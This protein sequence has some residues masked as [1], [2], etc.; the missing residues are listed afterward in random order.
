VIFQGGNP[1]VGSVNFNFKNIENYCK[2]HHFNLL[3][4]DFFLMLDTFLLKLVVITVENANLFLLELLV[5]VI[6]NII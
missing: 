2:E 5:I 3:Q 1:N 4:R 6:E